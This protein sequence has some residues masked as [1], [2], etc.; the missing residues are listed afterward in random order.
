MRLL[1]S[2]I[3]KRGSNNAGSIHKTTNI[4]YQLVLNLHHR[5]DQRVPEWLAL[6]VLQPLATLTLTDVPGFKPF[7]CITK[8]VK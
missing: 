3:Y 6:N 7:K 5:G 2:E 4:L 1:F 8:Q